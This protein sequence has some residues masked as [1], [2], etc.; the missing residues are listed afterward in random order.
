MSGSNAS[1]N[2]ARILL[3]LALVAA[4]AVTDADIGGTDGDFDG[5]ND[6]LDNC[7][8]VFNPDQADANNDS[9]GDLCDSESVQLSLAESTVPQ[10]ALVGSSDVARI[11]VRLR[12]RVTDWDGSLGLQFSRGDVLD[13][14][15][16][17]DADAPAIGLGTYPLLDYA[18]TLGGFTFGMQ[19]GEIKLADDSPQFGDQIFVRS[20][21][22]GPAVGAAELVGALAFFRDFDGEFLVGTDLITRAP[23]LSVMEHTGFALGFDH[24]VE[25]RI[26]VRARIAQSELVTQVDID[27]KPGSETNS[28]NPFSRGVVPVAIFGFEDFEVADIDVASLTFGFG[29]ALPASVSRRNRDVD[30]DGFPDLL[31]HFR[32]AETGIEIGDT[33]ACLSGETLDGTLFSGCDTIRTVPDR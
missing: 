10:S 21:A 20:V 25:G 27:I 32:I 26:L 22:I 14:V 17:Y 18:G 24:P 7:P 29:D 23:D 9:L 33:E 1:L 5:A 16:T 4:P 6:D 15:Y 3:T 28:I 31:L 2:L 30:A 13:V 11:S 12:G 8:F 19:S